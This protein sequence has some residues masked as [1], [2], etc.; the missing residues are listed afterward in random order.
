MVDK[1]VLLRDP[2]AECYTQ[3]KIC[4]WISPWKT[5]TTLS[6]QSALVWWHP[7]IHLQSIPLHY[8]R[9]H[10]RNSN[11]WA[12]WQIIFQK[13]LYSKNFF[14]LYEQLLKPKIQSQTQK[15]NF[16]K[17][18][19]PLVFDHLTPTAHASCIFCQPGGCTQNERANGIWL[20]L[21]CIHRCCGAS[22]KW[23][24]QGCSLQI[25]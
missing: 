15:V 24:S 14:F 7:I 25:G 19:L 10:Q 13:K 21:R 11:F 8:I 5:S 12:N 1:G 9:I 20:W 22:W 6:C 4:I 3:R 16:S 2:L 18:L 23:G 17:I